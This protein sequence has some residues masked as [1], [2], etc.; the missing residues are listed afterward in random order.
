MATSKNHILL[1][2]LAD[3]TLSDALLLTTPDSVRCW[4]GARQYTHFTFNPQTGHTSWIEYPDIPVWEWSKSIISDTPKFDAGKP[5]EAAVDEATIVDEFW[6]HNKRTPQNQLF[7]EHLLQDRF[8]DDYL[9]KYVDVRR[10]YEDIYVFDGKTYSGEEFR[11]KA[12]ERWNGDSLVNS[13]DTQLF[14][15]LAKTL[16]REKEITANR[17][18]FENVVFPAFNQVY[19]KEL[20]ANTI[21]YITMSDRVDELISKHA[22]YCDNAFLTPVPLDEV[23]QFVSIM[24]FWLNDSSFV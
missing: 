18:W 3:H 17:E 13:F 11:K 9:R 7:Y 23:E 16:Y 2:L 19:S 8:Y 22:F 20:A 5:G 14:M 15:V 1:A 24:R 12:E 10:R 21:K 4:S 6:L